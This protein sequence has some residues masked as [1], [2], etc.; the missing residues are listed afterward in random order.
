MTIEEGIKAFVQ[1]GLGTTR[2][3]SHRA[4]QVL[5]DPVKDPYIVFYRVSPTP[6]HTHLGPSPGIE[7]EFQFSVFHESQSTTIAV[8]DQL[9]RLLDG[10]RGLMGDVR[11]HAV[12]WAFDVYAFNDMTT[13]QLHQISTDFRFHYTEP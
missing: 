12:Y 2:V 10:Y 8:A 6:Q 7:R 3:Y 9:R 11:V 4:P 1:A 13:P 5:P